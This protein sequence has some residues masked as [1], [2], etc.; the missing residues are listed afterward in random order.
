MKT[1]DG[2]GCGDDARPQD[3]EMA[4]YARAYR[5]V[6]TA[7]ELFL[8]FEAQVAHARLIEAAPERFDGEHGLNCRQLAEGAR[9]A[10]R[11]MA[12]LLAE[13]PTPLCE[14][15][16]LKVHVFET[17]IQMQDEVARSNAAIM[18][19]AAMRADGERLGIVLIPLDRP[20][21]PTQ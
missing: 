10:A 11:R 13:A 1:N 14:V 21:G 4:L 16:A 3:D 7:D 15:L 9:I 18:L 17:L 6:L 5:G 19:E 20:S 2:S 12:I 8:R